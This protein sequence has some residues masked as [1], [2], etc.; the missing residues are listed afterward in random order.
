MEAKQYDT[1]QP[2]DHWRNQGGNLTLPGD[3]WQWKHDDPKPMGG[4][5]ISSNME[6]HSNTILFRKQEK[7]QINN[8]TL[9]LKQ[10]EKEEKT[11]HKFNRWK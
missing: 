3:K 5:K 11:K 8:L 1:K 2:I 7:S 4:S 9:H 10:V 6:V